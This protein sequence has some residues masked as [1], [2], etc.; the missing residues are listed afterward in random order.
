MAP[1]TL[2]TPP[3][4]AVPPMKHAAIA[5]SSKP[6][7]AAATPAPAREVVTMAAT[8]A[9][10]PMLTKIPKF[11]RR[12]LTPDRIAALRLPPIA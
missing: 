4:T 12:V 11:T 3:V 10:A 9:S 1:E 2:P 5:S 7:P 6:S 8:P